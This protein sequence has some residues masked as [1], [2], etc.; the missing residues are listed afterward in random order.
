MLGEWTLYGMRIVAV[1]AVSQAALGIFG[2]IGGPILGIFTLGL[3]YPWSN[4]KV[5]LYL[6]PPIAH[7]VKFKHYF[8]LVHLCKIIVPFQAYIVH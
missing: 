4:S 7:H 8:V 1:F 5:S 2:M 3:I 6:Y